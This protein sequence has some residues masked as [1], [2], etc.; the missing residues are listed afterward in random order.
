MTTAIARIEPKMALTTRYEPSNLE[1]AMT[2]ATKISKSGLCPEALRGKEADVLLVLLKGS[3]MG[4]TSMQSL[5]NLYVIHGRIGCSADLLRARAQAHPDCVRFE[6]VE[7]SRE[8][9]TLE[10]LKAGWSETITV[11]WTLQDAQRAGLIRQGSSHEKWPEEMNV[12]RVTSRAARRYFPEVCAGIYSKEE[13]E[14]ETTGSEPEKAVTPAKGTKAQKIVASVKAQ[15]APVSRQDDLSATQTEQMTT[16]TQESNKPAETILEAEAVPEPVSL[17]EEP[18]TPLDG[19]IS[20]W[21]RDEIIEAF[22]KSR[23]VTAAKAEEQIRAALSK[24]YDVENIMD[25]PVALVGDVLK[26]A[27]TKGAR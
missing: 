2:L 26:W 3:E 15:N 9:A 20:Q 22:I 11:T 21:T 4:L 24:R 18:E 25:L 19:K 14:A 12:A 13:L 16:S 23:G 6:I 1:E 5:Q 27:Q 17:F 7:A 10:V 8:K